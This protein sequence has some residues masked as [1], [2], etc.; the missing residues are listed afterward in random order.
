MGACSAHEPLPPGAGDFGGRTGNLPEAGSD[1]VADSTVGPE[2]DV[3][4]EQVDAAGVDEGG[5]EAQAAPGEAAADAPSRTGPFEG[6]D[7]SEVPPYPDEASYN[8]ERPDGSTRGGGDSTVC[9]QQLAWWMTGATIDPSVVSGGAPDLLNPLL[10]AQ[11]P[12][13]LADFADASGQYWLQISGTETNGISQQYFPYQYAAAPASLVISPG[14][15]PVLTATPSSAQPSG[16][17][18]RLIDSSQAEVWIEL[19][20]IAASA[21]AGDALCQTLTNGTLK[22]IIPATSGSTPLVIDG[23]TTTLAQVF[24]PMTTTTPAGWLFGMTFSATKT[25]GT[26]K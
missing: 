24:G 14:P 7:V 6:F 23:G 22:A 8:P 10:S 19:S 21:T 26:F 15:Y 20:Q 16:G 13:T 11:H 17:W 5:I 9:Y 18:L 1:A 12:L 25:Q 2:G 4:A 3:L